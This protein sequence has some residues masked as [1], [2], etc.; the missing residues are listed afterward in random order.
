M[1]EYRPVTVGAFDPAQVLEFNKILK[2]GG[3]I[4]VSAKYFGKRFQGR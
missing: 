3:L 2:E 1:Q 4:D